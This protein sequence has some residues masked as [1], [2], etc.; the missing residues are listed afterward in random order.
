MPAWT[1][2]T[3]AGRFIGP[4]PMDKATIVATARADGMTGRLAEDLIRLAIQA[5]RAYRWK[6]P[7]TNVVHLADT[8]QP[9]IGEGNRDVAN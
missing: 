9:I 8:P 7:R 4:K 1:P 2:E 3:F 5:G 6:M